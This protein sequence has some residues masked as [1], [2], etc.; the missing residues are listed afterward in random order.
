MNSQIYN[1]LAILNAAICKDICTKDVQL[2][3]PIDWKYLSVQARRQNLLPIFV[4][5]ATK[6]N[7]YQEY[8]GYEKDI[9]DAMIMVAQQIQKSKAFLDLYMAFL[10]RGI[11]PIVIKGIVLRQ[12]YG[13][14]KEHRVSADEDILV[15]SEE[16][17][18]VSDVLEQ[19][20]YRCTRSMLSK[21]QIDSMHEITFY[22]D[23]KDLCIEVHL[24]IIGKENS[25]RAYMN[26]AFE[27]VFE[28][29]EIMEIDGVPLKVLNPTYSLLFLVLHG[30]KHLQMGGMGVR[31]ILDILLYKEAYSN[32][33]KMDEIE[34]PLKNT[35]ADL[36]LRDVLWIGGQYFNLSYEESSVCCPQELLEDI[37]ETGIFGGSEKTDYL[38]VNI[39]LA[40][41]TVGKGNGKVKALIAG[42]FPPKGQLI[43]PYPYLVEK[44][45]L[46]PVAWIM[47]FIKFARYAGKDT[48]GI[49]NETLNKVGRREAILKK[50]KI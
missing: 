43:E 32:R 23:E 14:C 30:F 38:A 13:S 7:S 26:D 5:G 3:S 22:N 11:S 16:Y 44:P 49:V 10:N 1:F 47:R 37:I 35:H 29:T 36:F 50:Y 17:T 2:K 25:E 39:D 48:F 4:E 21:E 28:Q 8:A 41:K 24:N 6:Y 18:V 12:L 42:A 27:N 33:I 46:L 45:W 34:E 19:E 20:G 31:Q 15:R 9:Q 40:L